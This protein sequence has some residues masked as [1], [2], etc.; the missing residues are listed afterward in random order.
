[1]L[2]KQDIPDRLPRFIPAAG[3]RPI[4][5]IRQV[6]VTLNIQTIPAVKERFVTGGQRKEYVILLVKAGAY[7][8]KMN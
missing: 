3:E 8:L 1:M 2:L 5:N 6:R 4:Q 7:L